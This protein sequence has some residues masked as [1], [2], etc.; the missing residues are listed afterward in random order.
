MALFEVDTL[1]ITTSTTNLANGNPPAPLWGEGGTRPPNGGTKGG[2]G[3]TSLPPDLKGGSE[4]QTRSYVACVGN[5]GD[6]G[7]C[8]NECECRDGRTHR[9]KFI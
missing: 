1:L 3:D 8:E 4:Y 7:S 5:G 9:P 6:S 2:G